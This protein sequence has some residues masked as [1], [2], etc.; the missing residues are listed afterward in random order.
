MNTLMYVGEVSYVR[1][2]LAFMC[3]FFFFNGLVRLA[4]SDRR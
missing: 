1:L 2:K 3:S 4:S